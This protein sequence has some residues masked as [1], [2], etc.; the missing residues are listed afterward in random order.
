M[1]N[2]QFQS[3]IA[4]MAALIPKPPNVEI[5]DKLKRMGCELTT[6]ALMQTKITFKH[7]KHAADVVLVVLGAVRYVLIAASIV[8]LIEMMRSTHRSEFF[9]SFF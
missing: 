7:R 4:E 8:M 2:L 5:Q 6:N 3:V 1:P 9:L